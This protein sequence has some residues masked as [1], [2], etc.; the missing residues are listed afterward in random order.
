VAHLFNKCWG[1]YSSPNFSIKYRFRIVPRFEP[2]RTIFYAKDE[3]TAHQLIIYWNNNSIIN[4][5]GEH[6]KY[7]LVGEEVNASS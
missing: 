2:T 4:N 6:V 3:C 1:W 5:N 7:I